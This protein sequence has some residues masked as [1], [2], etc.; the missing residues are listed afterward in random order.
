MKQQQGH[1]VRSIL[2]SAELQTALSE[3]QGSAART[4]PAQCLP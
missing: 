4:A 1:G 3:E 2:R